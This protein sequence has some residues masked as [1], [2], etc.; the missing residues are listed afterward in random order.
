M[1][2]HR[3]LK[4]SRFP[5][6]T[7]S[8]EARVRQSAR[9]PIDGLE[10]LIQPWAKPRNIPTAT[11][12]GHAM[13][14]S[15]IPITTLCCFMYRHGVKTCKRNGFQVA[16]CGLK[17]PSRRRRPRTQCLHQPRFRRTPVLPRPRHLPPSHHC[18]EYQTSPPGIARAVSRY[19]TRAISTHAIP[20]LS[21]REIELC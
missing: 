8:V 9:L 7:T 20:A 3:G 4:Q 1:L 5:A 14:I 13:S 10:R 19:S 21:A 15:K 11:R 17:C 18:Q 12:Q 6:K 16:G 2:K